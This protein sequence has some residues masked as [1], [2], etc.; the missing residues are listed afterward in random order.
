[1]V[2]TGRPRRALLLAAL[3]SFALLAIAPAAGAAPKGFKF[4]VASGDVSANSAILWARA[5]KAGTALVQLQKGGRFESCDVSGAPKRFTVKAVKSNDFTVQTRV[6][7]LKPGRTYKYRWCM[8]GGRRSAVG[9]FDTAP[10]PSQAKTIHFSITGD[11]D[12]APLPGTTTPY[13]NNFGVWRQINSEENNFNVLM[14]D[15]IYSDSEVPGVGG[16]GGT[17]LSVAQKWAKY[18]MNLGQKPWAAIRGATSYYAHWDD[19]EFIND[20]ARSQ[21]VFPEEG[22]NVEYNGE[23]LYKNGVKAFRAYNPITYS[24]KNGI[25]RTFR[26]GKN[27]QVFFLDERSFRSA[28]ADYGGVCDNPAGSGTPDLAPT[29][30]AASR[31]LFSV[32]AP[33]LATPPPPACVA[34]INDPNRTMLG[35]H[36]LEVF[37]NAIKS[38]TAT[39]KVVMNEVPIQQFYALPYDRWEGYAA[40]R[41]KL[42]TFLRDNVKNVVFL[43][44]DV[45]ANLVNDARL[46]TL[47]AGGPI[48]TGITEVTT[49]PVA[50]KTYAGEINGTVGSATAATSIR[51]F[52]F[53]AQ[54]PTGVGMQ[55]SGL[56]Q[57][58]Y[59][60]VSVAKAALTV[61][62]KDIEGKPVQNTADRNKPAEPCAPIVITAQ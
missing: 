45:H 61:Q 37:E 43:T 23:Q 25:Y 5:N 14:G 56:D 24:A 2:A 35:Q 48:N 20:F 8:E 19:H 62:L 26:W 11:Q 52:F 10:S 60:E 17:A 59:A 4:G 49:G 36:Q 39:F 7:G 38:S 51:A 28:K 44:T 12:A 16:V 46:Q 9:S 33:S 30:P 29:A 32:I 1:M 41:T 42:L 6:N 55:C 50:T 3:C 31:A 58:S 18:R 40:E 34:A 53:N 54:P 21:N 13:W 22:G 15:T 27:L 47:E 57:F